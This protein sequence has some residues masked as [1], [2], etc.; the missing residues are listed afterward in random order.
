MGSTLRESKSICVYWYRV[1]LALGRLSIVGTT[2]KDVESLL[3][4][5]LADEKHSWI[6]GE[7]I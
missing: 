4:D 1:Y 6:K 2:I 3:K 5:L 7:K